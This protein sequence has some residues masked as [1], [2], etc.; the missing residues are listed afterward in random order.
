M[1]APVVP[2]GMQKK[3]SNIVK[4]F[5]QITLHS[6]NVSI[7]VRLYLFHHCTLFDHQGSNQRHKLRPDDQAN[8]LNGELASVLL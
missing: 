5:G 3:L 7:S 2:T 6:F 8:L 4:T 1:I